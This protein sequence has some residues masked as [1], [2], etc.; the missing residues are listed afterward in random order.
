M[1]MRSYVQKHVHEHPELLDLLAADD[2]STSEFTSGVGADGSGGGVST[3]RNVYP[4]HV[5]AVELSAG[6][7]SK[8]YLRGTIRVKR[9]DW[10]DCYVVV[11]T[12]EGEQRTS[13][14]VTGEGISDGSIHCC[15]VT[16][17][18]HTCI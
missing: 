13:V 18:Y 9:D 17:S 16:S 3:R 1:S 11:H 6:L 5:S 2:M 12:S 4:P 7:K 15:S 8:K 14:Q 10:S